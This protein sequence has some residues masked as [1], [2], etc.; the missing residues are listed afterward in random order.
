MSDGRRQLT[1]GVL[2][3][4]QY[5]GRLPVVHVVL[6][7]YLLKTKVHVG[8]V[9]LVIDSPWD[10]AVVRHR[11]LQQSYE[12]QRT[13]SLRRT[14]GLRNAW[15]LTTAHGAAGSL[16]RAKQLGRSWSQVQDKVA[17]RVVALIDL[18]TVS[19]LSRIGQRSRSS[20]G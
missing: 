13:S 3:D 4:V 6:V 20:P 7:R 18:Q 5:H 2:K 10:H 19:T 11:A 14:Y 1:Y 12:S 15:D 9:V 8:S 17:N 16:R